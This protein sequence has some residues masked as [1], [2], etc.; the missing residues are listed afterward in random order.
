MKRVKNGRKDF[1]QESCPFRYIFL[2]SDPF[3]K[4]VTVLLELGTL[5]PE[6]AWGGLIR[7]D[8]PG[9]LALVY[10]K[11]HAHFSVDDTQLSEELFI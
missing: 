4:N 6:P 8:S 3:V 11:R 10:G 9:S 7:I 5:A 1:F 2:S